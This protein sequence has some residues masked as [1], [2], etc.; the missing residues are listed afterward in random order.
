MFYGF[1]EDPDRTG[2][3]LC[4]LPSGTTNA[5]A[6]AE[7]PFRLNNV[8]AVPE[9]FLCAMITADSLAKA[10]AIVDSGVASDGTFPTNRILLQKTTDY[11]R[12]V[13][14]TAFDDV[15]FNFRVSG[16]TAIVQTNS[17]ET[18]G[19]TGLLGL[20]TG[21]EHLT[22]SPNSFLPGAMADSLTS[23]AGVIFG[24]NSQTNLLVFTDAGAAGAYGAVTEPCNY[25]QKFPAP[26]NYFF[27]H[28]G[29]NLVESYLMSITNPY[30]GLLVGEPLAVPFTRK[31][32]GAWNALAEGAILT[33]STNLSLQFTAADGPRPIQRVELFV[34]GVFFVTLTNVPPTP[35]NL[36]QAELNGVT[37]SYMVQTNDTIASVAAGLAAE[38]NTPANQALLNVKAAAHGD[39][40]ELQSEDVHRLGAD[41][42]IQASS[43]ATNDA[44]RTTFLRVS[45]TNFLDTFTTGYQQYGIGV[46]VVPDDY[47]ILTT[48]KTNGAVVTVAITNHAPSI[49]LYDFVRDFMNQINATPALQGADGVVA[50][51][52]L[53]ETS[54]LVSF[55]L[56]PR[57][58]GREAAQ[59][60][61]AITGLFDVYPTNTTIRLEQNLG[62][63]QPRNHAY[64]T[65][66]A[67]ELDVTFALDTTQLSDG[68]HELTAVAYEGSHIAT[69]TQVSRSVRVRNGAVSATLTPSLTASN[70]AV[71]APLQFEVSANTNLVD[72]I[73]L[74]STGGLLASVSNVSSITFSVTGNNLGVGLHPFRAVVTAGT[75][76]YQTEPCF[77]RL[78]AVEPSFPI[79]LSLAPIRLTW[80]A[81]AGRRYD[82]L[83]TTNLIL[84]FSVR[85]T[86]V[87][88]NTAPVTWTETESGPERFY[89]VRVAF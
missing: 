56:R 4:T 32:S 53:V 68:W 11:A 89:R 78:L 71:E 16:S 88:T 75:N 1:K 51:E 19:L 80:N 52:L 58:A 81:V 74:F 85:E 28:R 48:T 40:I 10:K 6:G 55:Y 9:H 24:P 62:D 42:T 29:F 35:G 7:T 27:Q 5:F 20:Q 33:G 86:V 47:L 77:I 25:P 82:V 69:Q 45:R 3:N 13:R 17:N 50:D 2:Q 46:A 37:L 65:A 22:V 59:V 63:L 70:I 38:F 60:Q 18:S 73:E 36:V 72:R 26:L 57:S 12:N 44:A 30:M 49:S 8:G 43:V 64:V 67:S 79:S 39:R 83:S 34:D 61:T 66:G 76:V 23:Y 41:M 87:A 84:P 31:A 54:T 21:L 14:F 15:D